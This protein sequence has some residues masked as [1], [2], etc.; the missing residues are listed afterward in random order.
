MTH[1]QLLYHKHGV[2]YDCSYYGD[3]FIY[4][5][6]LLSSKNIKTLTIHYK[7]KNKY[8][9]TTLDKSILNAFTLSVI[10][11]SS[12][13]DNNNLWKKVKH[14]DIDKDKFIYGFVSYITLF[15]L[16]ENTNFVDFLPFKFNITCTLAHGD[17]CEYHVMQ[18]IREPLDAICNLIKKEKLLY[19]YLSVI[20]DFIDKHSHM[21]HMGPQI[22]PRTVQKLN[23]DMITGTTR[24]S[25]EKINKIKK[26]KKNKKN[27]KNNYAPISGSFDSYSQA[28][29]EVPNKNNY[30][31]I[32]GSFDSYSQLSEELPN[33]QNYA[34]ICGSFDSYTQLSEEI[35]EE[36]IKDTYAPIRVR[37][38][39]EPKE[40][41]TLTECDKTYIKNLITDMIDDKYCKEVQSEQYEQYEQHDRNDCKYEIDNKDNYKYNR[42][43]KKC[44]NEDDYDVIGNALKHYEKDRTPKLKMAFAPLQ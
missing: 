40:G 23:L 28:S 12:D 13:T 39:C 19:H 25:I 2:D 18:Y 24:Y 26:K 36:S 1:K 27:V 41:I 43:E 34:P 5:D 37:C 8:I 33:T 21:F 11:H 10:N 42:Y 32:C 6:T 38:V 29:E 44:E 17:C 35:Q 4:I 7:F 3:E 14:F 16:F 22:H 20:V 15:F 31:P 9:T 30:A